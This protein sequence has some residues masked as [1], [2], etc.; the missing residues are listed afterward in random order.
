MTPEP[1]AHNIHSP[2][3]RVTCHNTIVSCRH[4]AP[5]QEAESLLLLCGRHELIPCLLTSGRLNGTRREPTPPGHAVAPITVAVG[6]YRSGASQVHMGP[7]TIIK[8]SETIKESEMVRFGAGNLT[9]AVRA[10]ARQAAA[11]GFAH[12]HRDP[13]CLARCLQC[14]KKHLKVHWL[15]HVRLHVNARL[16]LS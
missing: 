5:S 1:H 7:D 11:E 15:H 9:I 16:H 13:A 8:E 6:Y 3:G 12:K 10:R 14:S 2:W 4:R